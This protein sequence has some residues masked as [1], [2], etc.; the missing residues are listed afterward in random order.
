MD[1]PLDRLFAEMVVLARRIESATRRSTTYRRMERAA[2]LI[3][4]ALDREGPSSV[5]E[6]AALL[7]LDGSTVTRQVS[8]MESRGQAA[9]SADPDDGRAWLIDLTPAGRDEMRAIAAAGRMRFAGYT[10]EWQPE[11]VERFGALLQKF[12]TAL[13]TPSVVHG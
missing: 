7:M 1:E 13:A 11:E 2:Y 12:N 9:R 8:A 10:A 6:L 5:S 4:C 3:A